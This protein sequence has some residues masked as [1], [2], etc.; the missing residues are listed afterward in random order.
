MRNRLEMAVD[1]VHEQGTPVERARLGYL[2]QGEQ[3]QRSMVNDL[4][5]DQRL[6][7]GWAPFWAADYSSL[8]AACTRLAQAEQS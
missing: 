6:D 5:A 3:L 8:N 2:L 1:F 7:G 4:L